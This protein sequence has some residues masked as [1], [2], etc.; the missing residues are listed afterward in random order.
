[1]RKIANETKKR[2]KLLY[3]KKFDSIKINGKK[4]TAKDIRI[5]TEK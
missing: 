5:V 4:L 1:M 3:E 2:K